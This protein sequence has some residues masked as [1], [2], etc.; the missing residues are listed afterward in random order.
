MLVLVIEYPLDAENCLFLMLVNVGQ[1][2]F[3]EIL[4]N[5]ACE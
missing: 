4:V 3:T 5:K 1:R 2:N